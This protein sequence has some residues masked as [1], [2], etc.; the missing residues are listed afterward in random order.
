MNEWIRCKWRCRR[1]LLQGHCTESSTI[2]LSVSEEMTQ[3]TYESLDANTRKPAMAK[4]SRHVQQ[5]QGTPRVDQRVDGTMSVDVHVLA[6]LSRRRA[7]S[8]VDRWS[9]S[10]RYDGVRPCRHQN[11]RTHNRYWI[12]SGTLSQWSS[13]SSWRSTVMCSDLLAENTSRAA[14][15]STDWSRCISDPWTH[16]PTPNNRSQPLWW[17]VSGSA[18]ARHLAST[19]AAH[20]VSLPQCSETGADGRGDVSRHGDV[21]VDVDP[22][23]ADGRLRQ[24]S[25]VA[26][27]YLSGWDLMSTT[28]WRTPDYVGLDG[29]ELPP[30]GHHPRWHLVDTVG[31]TLL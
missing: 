27:T 15:F 29:V 2:A 30:I 22:E 11:A 25:R 7:S 21:S 4:N 12:L 19:N 5:P 9:V 8:S 24:K 3:R 23:V 1:K 16:Q 13:R 31:D 17:E 18:S 6:D 26:N 14:A 28:S 10:E 20:Y